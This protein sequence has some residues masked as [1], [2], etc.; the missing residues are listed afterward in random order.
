MKTAPTSV[1][2]LRN[3]SERQDLSARVDMH[4]RCVWPGHVRAFTLIELLVVVS[5][6]ALLVSMLLPALNKAREHARRT[7]CMTNVK[8][9]LAGVLIYSHENNDCMPIFDSP[10]SELSLG[11]S[12]AM[13]EQILYHG[14]IVVL[15][16]LYPE[17]VDDGHVY[18]CPSDTRRNSY[19]DGR[20]GGPFSDLDRGTAVNL[21]SSYFTRGDLVPNYPYEG[22]NEP[23]SEN[24]VFK[25]E[26]ILWKHPNWIIMTDSGTFWDGAEASNGLHYTRISHP[27]EKGYP[28][29]FNNGWADGH[30]SA[31]RVKNPEEGWPYAI[32]GSSYYTNAAGMVRMQNE[33]W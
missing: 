21:E 13:R 7:V 10:K 26:K 23:F 14:D 9:L 28:D 32:A 2:L 1:D 24:A 17:Y 18:F 8:D 29:Y 16:K 12:C 5:I 4:A 15:G 3:P 27:D 22:Y 33:D 11:W 25:Y 30:V 6:I 20:V 31:Y 19:M